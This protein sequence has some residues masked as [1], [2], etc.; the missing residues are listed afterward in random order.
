MFFPNIFG[1]YDS[2]DLPNL[3]VA[4]N[5]ANPGGVP[6][7]QIAAD[8]KR[9]SDFYNEAV[10]TYENFLAIRVQQP[11]GTFG[12]GTA[13]GEMQPYAEY[14]QTEATRVE[15]NQWTWGIPIQRY[16]DAVLYT[17]EYLATVSLERIALDTIAATNRN[18]TT[19]MKQ[20]LRTI[21]RNTNRTFNDS[22]IFP[23]EGAGDV[24]VLALFNADG[25]TARL[26]VDNAIVS[27]G[28]L[29][30]YMP[31]GA[32]T[33]TIANFTIGRSKLR[34]R[35]YLGRVVHIISPTDVDTVKGLTGFVPLPP[36]PSDVY[37]S[38]TPAPSTT[39]AVVTAPKAIGSIQ[40]SGT[41]D[42]EVVVFPFFPAG[43][44]MSIDKT[45]EVPLA[46]RERKEPQFRG[47]RLIQDETRGD[48]GTASLRNKK[49]EYIA[50][51]AVRNRANGVV[52]RAH[53]DTYTAP[54]I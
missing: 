16:R 19:R 33:I 30:S 49:W 54:T 24:S 44:T 53:A 14:G 5:G 39:T 20:M 12:T 11:S 42:G 23:G 40:N 46:I 21:F 50:G 34:E 32:G 9:W 52:V 3:R 27:A 37:A 26:W 1:S 15:D 43:Y 18:L 31:S 22:A 51:V 8:I 7:A 41:S 28:T 38:T 48:Y 10:Q 4:V 25:S 47:F 35:G 36:D 6:E 13:G 45:K 2:R 17:E 29:Q